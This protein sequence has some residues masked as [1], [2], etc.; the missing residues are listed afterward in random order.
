MELRG[1]RD[2]TKSKTVD[3]EAANAE[4]IAYLRHSVGQLR[5]QVLKKI[6]S[7][8]TSSHAGMKDAEVQLKETMKK[9][10]DRMS[11]LSEIA[12]VGERLDGMYHDLCDKV[13]E[14][15]TLCNPE[16]HSP[17]VDD[18]VDDR[19]RSHQRSPV[20]LLDTT[21][22][23]ERNRPVSPLFEEIDRKEVSVMLAVPRLSFHNNPASHL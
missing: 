9:V 12:P 7:V 23:V 4:R 16:T 14:T 22:S 21:E 1:A 11:Q 20:N 6:E 3:W 18:V 19:Q 8:H 5:S 15:L 13:K 10:T 2:R 17:G